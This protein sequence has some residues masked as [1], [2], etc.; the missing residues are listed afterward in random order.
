[1]PAPRTYKTEVIVIRQISF[2]EA[3]RILTLYS[4]DLG[5]IRAVA[6]GIRRHKNKLRGQLE[7]VS[8][9]SVSISRGR[10]LD[11][12]NEAK[13]IDSYRPV[14]EELERLTIGLYLAELT[15]NFGNSINLHNLMRRFELN[16]LK[17]SGFDPELYHCIECQ[18]ELEQR[19]HLFSCPSGGVV[20]TNCRSSTDVLLPLSVNSMKFLRFV[21]REPLFENLENLKVSTK[22]QT[23]VQHL[24][25]T[26]LRYVSERRLKTTE[27]LDLTLT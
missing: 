1:M 8:R 20:C 5:K 12:I 26:Y 23:E 27:L 22:S 13:T 4:P 18:N 15:D 25:R 11:T 9:A 19:D 14:R 7:L 16:L 24:L 21:E 2:G 10:N 17:H 6:K 3:D